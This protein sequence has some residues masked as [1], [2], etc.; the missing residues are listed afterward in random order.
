[1]TTTLTSLLADPR[2]HTAAS[3]KTPAPQK[4]HTPLPTFEPAQLHE[5][6]LETDLPTPTQ[7]ALLLTLLA[8]LWATQKLQAPGGDP[9]SM[10]GRPRRDLRIVYIGKS[11][12][13]SFQLVAAA[14]APSPLQNALFLDPLSD[15]EKFWAIGQA[16]RCPALTAIIAD[17]SRLTPTISRRLQLAAESQSNSERAGGGP[18]AFLARPANEKDQPSWA[19]SRWNV[20]PL[21]SDKQTPQWLL[22]CFSCRRQH[23]GQDAPRRWIADGSYQVLR[24]TVT[25]HLSPD[26]GHRTAHTPPPFQ[27]TRSARTA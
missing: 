16:L 1:M 6:F 5:F 10:V 14:M 21:P 7:P 20:Q 9:A 27:H 17:A 19:A 2:L 13:P 15:A 25:F 4:Q 18:L 8:T 12:W 3:L 11:C 23:A 26:V 24:G 22:E